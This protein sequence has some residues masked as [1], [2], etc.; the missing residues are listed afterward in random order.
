M[1]PFVADRTTYQ[2]NRNDG[3]AIAV[4]GS[5]HGDVYFPRGTSS[6]QCL[7]DL[8][9]T[10]P[11]EDK[12]R[13]EDDKDKL[14]R[15][16]YAWILDDPEFQR[17]RTHCDS[18]LLWIKGD[19]GKGKTMMMI[20]LINE[21]S[22]AHEAGPSSKRISKF[23]ARFKPK[24][25]SGLISYFFCQSTRPELNNA[26]S[27]L[28]GLIYLLIMQK[29]DLMRHVRKRYEATGSKLFEGH[30]AIYSLREI[31]SDILNDSA[32]PATYLLVDAIDECS[33]GLSQLLHFISDD[34]LTRRSKVKWLVTSRNLPHIEQFLRA[35][36]LRVTISLELN[37]RHISKAVM[38]FISFKVDQLAT[39]LKYDSNTRIEV[40]ELL[41][42]KAEGTFL[43]VS[44]V[45]KELE[46]VP[47][48]RTRSVLRELP[49]GLDP[50]YDRMMRQILAQKE[51]ETVR[52][53]QDA[54]RSV[55]L[56]Y[57]P[58]QLKEL[59]VAAGLPYDQFDVVHA[60]SDLVS[61][62]GSFL[63][64]REGTVFF[65]H[66]SAKGYF[67][68]G[69]GRKI[70]V[71]SVAE[72]QEKITHRLLDKMSRDTLQRDMCGMEKPG[73]RIQEAIR[74]IDN[75]ALPQI[76]YACQYWVDHLATCVEVCRT[77]LSD[78]GK[79]HNFL[80]KHLLHWLEAMSLMQKVPEAVAMMQKLHSILDVSVI[81]TM[82]WC[83][84]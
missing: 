43:W 79:V 83:N 25:R 1:P 57:R 62:C 63:T 35:N 9:V 75:S 67:T 71:D 46:R 16:C 7:R 22:C 48:Y 68:S 19:P 77:I 76:A 41:C 10:N 20:G 52:F 21:L 84:N 72:E 59:V 65:V 28:R 2:N 30:S 29:E 15:D 81:S 18:R 27:V 44:L 60:V 40:Q 45:C 73:T 61:R 33:T 54:L 53:C 82:R 26:V 39:M 38:A 3:N 6:D 47:L 24:P 23:L 14:L 49:P 13:I 4:L 78:C 34:N 37:S 80:Q 36:S 5:I 32:L 17:W 51:P 50:L 74:R 31:L 66:L 42:E 12:T 8:R 58:L 55:T 70:F 69:E 64:I 11:K 56:T